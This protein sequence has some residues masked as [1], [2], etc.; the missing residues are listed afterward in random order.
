[1]LK[2]IIRVRFLNLSFTLDIF[3]GH[4]I[5]GCREIRVGGRA[6]VSGIE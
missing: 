4:S 5:P 3:M 6:A 2:G 1:M